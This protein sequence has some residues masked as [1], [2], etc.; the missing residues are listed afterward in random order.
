MTKSSLCLSAH[1]SITQTNSQ[2]IIGQASDALRHVQRTIASRIFSELSDDDYHRYHRAYSPGIQEYIEARTFMSYCQ[3]EGLVTAEIVEMELNKIEGEQGRQLKTFPL[4]SSDYVLGVADL[5]G[6]LMRRAVASSA[7]E[8]VQIHSF[9]CEIEHG[10]N[11]LSQRHNL[12][13]D[14]HFKLKSLQQSV[15][16]VQKACFDRI[17]QVAEFGNIAEDVQPFG[18]DRNIKKP[19]TEN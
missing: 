4:D 8:A 12:G 19:R 6:E 13:K 15:S 16:K 7:K 5:T 1:D 9:L 14:M 18:S 2:K 17:I 11:L 3:G 10:M